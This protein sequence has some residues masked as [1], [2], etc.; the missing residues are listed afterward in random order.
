MIYL[1][2]RTGDLSLQL[3]RGQFFISHEILK[4]IWFFMYVL[5]MFYILN[6]HKKNIGATLPNSSLHDSIQPFPSL[7][8]LDKKM[9]RSKS[10]PF[11]S[12]QAMEANSEP[13][14]KMSLDSYLDQTILPTPIWKKSEGKKTRLSRK[15][16][17]GIILGKEL[18]INAMKLNNVV[19]EITEAATVFL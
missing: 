17:T 11:I 14:R 1:I 5:A 10:L 9:V 19:G 6:N 13:I 8:A 18:G 15:K 7:G 12:P 3:F 16:M 2:I 4:N